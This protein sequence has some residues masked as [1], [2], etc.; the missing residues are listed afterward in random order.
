MFPITP[1]DRSRRLQYVEILHDVGE[2]V[3]SEDSEAAQTNPDP[4]KNEGDEG[5]RN[6]E[7]VD[8]GV[9]VEHKE[10][11]V[12]GSDESHEEVGNEQHVEYKVK[13]NR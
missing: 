7:E 13:L 10:Q 8:E 1:P 11:F 3:E 9:E 12:I 4:A 6:C 2:R 5:G